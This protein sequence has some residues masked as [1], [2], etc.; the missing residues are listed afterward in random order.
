MPC[1]LRHSK[2]AGTHCVLVMVYSQIPCLPS[3]NIG[4]QGY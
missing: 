3:P 2:F 4:T 1:N